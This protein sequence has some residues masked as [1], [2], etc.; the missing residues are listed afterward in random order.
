MDTLDEVLAL[1]GWRPPHDVL[2]NLALGNPWVARKF[3]ACADNYL[4]RD[5]DATGT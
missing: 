5:Q 3:F 2:E 1:Y 4:S